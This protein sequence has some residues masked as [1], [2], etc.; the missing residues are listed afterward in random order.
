M[1]TVHGCLKHIIS[2]LKSSYLKFQN[3]V[4]LGFGFRV[5]AAW[6]YLQF[7]VFL[8]IVCQ[9]IVCVFDN[10]SYIGLWIAGFRLSEFRLS[11]FRFLGLCLLGIVF[12][13]FCLS[14]FARR[15]LFARGYFG[16][17][18]VNT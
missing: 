10:T 14:D 15:I 7:L 16:I 2:I 1:N 12:L 3:F 8:K 17:D 13:V 9:Y 11:G 4:F 18:C 6:I 5:L